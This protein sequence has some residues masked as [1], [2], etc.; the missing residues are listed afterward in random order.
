ML[1]PI[2]ETDVPGLLQILLGVCA[3]G[4]ERLGALDPGNRGELFGHDSCDRLVIGDFDQCDEIPLARHR[5]DARDTID[6]GQPR[7]GVR[8]PLW[9]GFDE[10]NGG[11]HAVGEDYRS[12]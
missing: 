10:D 2:L 7:G 8:D 11:D 3:K 4:R 1:R 9:I 6:P 5:V 12:V